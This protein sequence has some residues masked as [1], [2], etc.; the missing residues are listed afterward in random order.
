MYK[1]YPKF[2]PEEVLV[3]LRKSRADDDNLTVAEVLERHEND[4]RQWAERNLD[5]PIPNDNWYREVVSGESIQ[6]REEFKKLLKRIESKSITAVIV[7]DC[8]RLGR[9]SLEEIGRIA[10]LFRYTSTYIISIMPYKVFDLNDKWDRQQFESEMMRNRDYLDYTKGILRAGKE[11]SL[12]GGWHINGVQPYGYIRE[13]VIDGKR[14]R[15]TLAIVEDEAKVVRMIFDWYVNEGIGA[16]K[17]CQRLNDMGIPSRKGMKWKKSSVHNI[18]KNEHYMGKIVIRKYIDVKMVEDSEI[19]THCV[20]NEEYEIVDGRHPAIIDEETFYKAQNRIRRIP[21]VPKNK[22]L[23]N[24]FASILKCECGR[25]MVRR[26]NRNTFRHQCDDNMFCNNASC[27]E[28][29]LIKAVMCG[30]TEHLDNLTTKVNDTDE[31][32]MQKHRD[33][34][35]FLEQ[36]LIDAENKEIALWDKYTDEKMPKKVFDNLL[37]K[38]TEEKTK[39]ENAL[40]EAQA[41][42]PKQVDYA[43]AIATLHECIKALGSE[44]VSAS[45]K[46][47]LLLSVV[48]EIIYSRPKAVRISKEEAQEKGITLVGGWYCPDFTLDIHLKV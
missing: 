4:I 22:T 38:N 45:A 19:T 42:E 31:N 40:N 30:L 37:A 25:V 43:G 34:I 2:N 1:E 20:K 23:Q 11:N 12:R 9:P 26:K 16:T 33:H 5:A 36:K 8:A 14:E 7:K 18:L 35:A 41:N 48:D 15:P 21:S 3:Y 46:N 17:I 39:L 28:E 10:S 24:P 29:A 44:S 6:S 27:S 47:K 32:K 13:W